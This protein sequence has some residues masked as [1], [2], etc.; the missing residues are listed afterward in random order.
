MRNRLLLLADALLVVAAVVLAVRVY[1]VWTARPAA[2]PV[3]APTA[4]PETAPASGP[5]PP[6]ARPPL[7]AFA[8]VAER[9]LFSPTRTEAGS[10]PARSAT[11]A[12]SSAPAARP[13][14]YGVLLGVDGGR[15]YLEDPRT[16]KIFAYKIGDSIADNRLEQIQADRVVMRRG[17]EVFEVLLRDPSK[18]K[19][20]VAPQPPAAAGRP[21]PPGTVP[22]SPGSPIFPG[23]PVTPAPQ[24]PGAFG[25]PG[26]EPTAPVRPTPRVPRRLFPEPGRPPTAAPPPAPDGNDGE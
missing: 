11:P 25:A 21:Q 10:D 2:P 15:A 8:V 7:S 14:L 12:A 17:G 18:P 6:A 1:G 26:S 13:R 23:V 22:G 3:P 24:A 9:N 20:P 4:A 16:R 19:P 5:T